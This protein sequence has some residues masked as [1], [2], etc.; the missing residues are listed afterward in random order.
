MSI[1]VTKMLLFSVLSASKYIFQVIRFSPLSIMI[2]L[3]FNTSVILSVC[4]KIKYLDRLLKVYFQRESQ[5]DYDCDRYMNSL[6]IKGCSF[7]IALDIF[8]N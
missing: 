6:R 3:S 8:I 7:D 2:H 1:S 5:S 4:T